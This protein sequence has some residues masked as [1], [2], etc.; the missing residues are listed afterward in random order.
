MTDSKGEEVYRLAEERFRA[1]LD[2]LGDGYFEVDLA[3]TM[4]YCNKV[5]SCLF[6]YKHGELIGKNYR[7]Y[8]DP[9][10]AKKIYEAFN[11]VYTTGL[12]LKQFEMEVQNK[13]GNIRH[14]ETSVALI[15][16]RENRKIGFRGIV[17]DNT[18]KKK[19]ETALR[20]SEE[21][22]RTILNHM[23]EGYFEVDL[24]GNMLYC[25]EAHGRIYGIPSEKMIGLNF[26]EYISPETAQKIYEI[27]NRVYKTGEPE[28]VEDFE[29]IRKDGTRFFVA[30]S[31]ALIRDGQGRKIGFRGLLRDI[32][33]EKEAKETLQALSLKDDLTGLYNRRGFL[34]L[35]ELVLKSAARSQKKV[36]LLFADLDDLK[37][38]NDTY[39]HLEGDRALREVARVLLDNFREPDLLARIGGD[40]FV[41]LAVEGEEGADTEIFLER[42]RNGLRQGQEDRSLPYALSMS[43]GVVCFAPEDNQSIESLLEEADRRMYQ[44]KQAKKGLLQMELEL[45][46]KGR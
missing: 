32:T 30:S 22:Y 6:G 3:G 45:F 20:Q 25:N 17:R 14:V 46:S 21:R 8:T 9:E 33:R 38:I 41:V 11:R 40:E 28:K 43:M 13:S 29:L 39:G 19:I 34:A 24:A 18:E 31:V 2:G 5:T 15:F 4:V 44:D 26:R 35:A 12:P 36:Y 23:K 42:L 7:E 16:D 10:M 37:T 27:Y 1:L